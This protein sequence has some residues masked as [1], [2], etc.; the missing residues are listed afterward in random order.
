MNST[1]HIT[2]NIFE[3]SGPNKKE[4]K[5]NGLYTIYNMKSTAQMVDNNLNK[6]GPDEKENK[7][8]GLYTIYNMN[9]T[10]PMFDNNLK[11]LTRNKTRNMIKGL[12]TIY[13]MNSNKQMAVKQTN[14]NLLDTVVPDI[15]VPIMK[16]TERT[17]IKRHRFN[18]RKWFQNAVVK[19]TSLQ[20]THWIL[21]TEIEKIKKLPLPAKI[22]DLV[23]LV[24]KSKYY[25]VPF[26]NNKLSEKENTAFVNNAIVYK[27][28]VLNLDDP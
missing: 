19:Q 27:L 28:K 1:A 12:S 2:D 26:Q 3:K 18:S 16:T 11:K 24:R 9:S 5:V 23:D 20:I 15:N 22:K 10:A 21:N 14:T 25:K 6:S 4:N 13:N 8:R 7:I 17:P